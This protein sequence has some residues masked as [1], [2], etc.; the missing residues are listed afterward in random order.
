MSREW[1][2]AIIGGIIASAV[3]LYLLDPILKFASFVFF[4]VGKNVFRAYTDR[5]FA[6]AALLT[7]PDPGLFLFVGSVVTFSVTMS[8]VVLGIILQRRARRAERPPRAPVRV[9]IWILLLLVLLSDFVSLLF[10][11]N[12][13]F[14]IRIITSFNQHLAAVAPFI[15]DQD[16]KV[17]RSQWT[18]MKTK[19]DYDA[20]YLKLAQ[21]ANSNGIILPPNLVFTPTSL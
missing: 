9:Q 11:Y 18:Q 10:L 20:I 19:R 5:L 6:Q 4:T 12:T 3:F 17:L 14:Q 7:G 15:S 8:I 16:A 1:K 13:F 21:V 2:I